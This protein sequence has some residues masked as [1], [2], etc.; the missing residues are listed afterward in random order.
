MA[1]RQQSGS[2]QD[3]EAS[4]AVG[5]VML[6]AHHQLWQRQECG[7]PLAS[8]RSAQVSE[9]VLGRPIGTSL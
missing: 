2:H 6:A 1:G 5:C 8:C 9:A 4:W 3:C 7:G